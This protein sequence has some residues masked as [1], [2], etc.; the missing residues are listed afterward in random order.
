[1]S[2]AW[3]PDSGLVTGDGVVLDLPVARVPTRMLAYLIDITVEVAVA[4]A[5]GLTAVFLGVGDL[6]ASAV[7]AVVIA[8]A[9]V[10]FLGYPVAFDTLNRGRTLG[11]MALGLRTVRDDGGAVS[12]GQAL[13]RGIAGLVDFPATAWSG[14][15]VSAVLSD[16]DKRIGDRLA[17][18]F[19]V[20]ERAPRR[21]RRDPVAPP[22]SLTPWTARSD[23]VG[24]DD[25]L[26]SRV[27]SYLDRRPK[28]SPEADE[29]LGRQLA[30]A[31]AA[32]VTPPPPGTPPADYLAAVL[33]GCRHRPRSGGPDQ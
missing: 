13:V 4:A 22:A 1:M 21:P 28:L 18:T 11:K 16:R 14:G 25:A 31:V 7:G 12:F 2:T 6:S 32:R 19:V 23:L 20:R 9:A 33:A 3:E 26:A 17:G 15:L 24:L 30:D 27:R 8:G 10:V 5:L 29:R